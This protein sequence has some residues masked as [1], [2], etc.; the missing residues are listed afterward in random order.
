MSWIP[1]ESDAAAPTE[2]VV[3]LG[4][5]AAVV[6]GARLR[7]G[8]AADRTKTIARLSVGAAVAAGEPAR[9]G[10]G[11]AVER[12]YCGL[13]RSRLREAPARLDRGLKRGVIGQIVDRC[14]ASVDARRAIRRRRELASGRDRGFERC[15]LKR[16]SVRF[17]DGRRRERIQAPERVGPAR[18]Q[19]HAL[20]G[21][22]FG[23][24][25]PGDPL[26]L[27]VLQRREHQF[28]LGL[29]RLAFA[30][31]TGRVGERA[32]KPARRQPDDDAE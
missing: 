24:E 7:Q 17:H 18:H 14:R 15:T 25:G 21:E 1:R 5:F 13:S 4:D 20:L 6:T 23:R 30:Q 8:V 29:E 10:V 12:L 9:A 2:P 16:R 31:R 28:A 27:E 26:G 32:A 11:L 22:V 3:R 19:G